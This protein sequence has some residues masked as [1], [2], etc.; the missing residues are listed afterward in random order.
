MNNSTHFK[1]LAW[2]SSFHSDD[3]FSDDIVR[4]I[5]A[6][7]GIYAS[8]ELLFAWTIEEK[9]ILT[10]LEGTFFLLTLL[11]AFLFQRRHPLFCRKW[12]PS[13]LF[14]G[15]TFLLILQLLL[16]K[17]YSIG[18]LC[19]LTSFFFA[20]LAY[21]PTQLPKIRR[22]PALIAAL[23]SLLT[24]TLFLP[25]LGSSSTLL[26][27][28][29]NL[30]F[31][32]FFSWK[33]IIPFIIFII[34]FI[35]QHPFFI[36]T[37]NYIP[38]EKKSIGRCHFFIEKHHSLGF[39]LAYGCGGREFF[40]SETSRWVEP[41]V[42]PLLALLEHPTRVLV[43]GGERGFVLKELLNDVA[44]KRIDLLSWRQ[45]EILFFSQ[46]SILRKLNAHSFED[47]RVH[48]KF[49]PNEE[50]FSHYLRQIRFKYDL[51]IQ[52][53][54]PRWA[55]GEKFYEKAHFQLLRNKLKATGY[56]GIFWG[57]ETKHFVQMSQAMKGAG[58]FITPYR[59]FGIDITWLFLIGSP[60]SFIDFRK[61]H[62]SSGLNY[63]SEDLLPQLFHFPLDRRSFLP[64]KNSKKNK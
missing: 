62:L 30:F 55:I 12:A 24:P 59:S 2:F 10:R 50:A 33:R 16:Q 49:F 46:H 21:P 14:W 43:L 52:V 29:L 9:M 11:I 5:T 58:F 26:L 31:R 7:F 47:P 32:F 61:L 53:L 54:E 4:I 37:S 38:L 13:L 51:I 23:L 35:N 45:E 48:L 42:A 17:G 39:Y 25:Y 8:Q 3:P 1:Y 64:P 15:L 41:L 57:V 28:L 19:W 63:L 27:L 44:I 18:A 34:F 22:W 6:F 60:S 56:L 20:S 40:S 36:G